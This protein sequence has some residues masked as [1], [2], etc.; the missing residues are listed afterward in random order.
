MQTLKSVNFRTS[1]TIV[2]LL[3]VYFMV[4][5]FFGMEANTGMR[6]LNAPIIL[7]S[8]ATVAL[9]HKH[10]MKEAPFQAYV[11]IGF[12]AA[13]GFAVTFAIYISTINPGLIATIKEQVLFSEAVNPITL[14]LLLFVE[15]MSI[16]VASAFIVHNAS[17]YLPALLFRK[18][19]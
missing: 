15:T 19:Q 1:A 7:L 11:K 5:L 9:L 2:L 17:K 13:L 14:M 8:I 16:S 3:W 18:A 12:K 6:F 4:C 10:K